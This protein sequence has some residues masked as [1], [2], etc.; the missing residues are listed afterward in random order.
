MKR[1]LFV[2]DSLNGGG[3]EKILL[4]VIGGLDKELYEI[5]LQVIWNRGYYL[6]RIPSCV[7]YHSIISDFSNSFLGKA[8]RRAFEILLKR[9]NGQLLHKLFIRKKYDVEI[10]FLEGASTK[11]VSGASCRKI[12]WVHIDMQA[13]TWY[14]QFYSSHNQT[15][16]TYRN[17]DKIC[18]VSNALK[19]VFIEKFGISDKCVVVYNPV[20]EKEIK[21]LS[22]LPATTSIRAKEKVFVTVGRLEKQKGYDRLIAAA[23]RLNKQ[24]YRFKIAILGSGSL[25][26]E[27]MQ[28]C[29]ELGVQEQVEFLGYQPNPYSIISQADVFICSSRSEGFSTAVTEALV[30]GIPVI[31]TDC[32]GMDELLCGGS[33][34]MIFQNSVDGIENGMKLILDNETIEQNLRMAA[35]KRG[36]DFTMNTSMKHIEEII[37]G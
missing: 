3:A 27:L 32:A 24:Q 37:N 31:T 8:K 16:R 33:C 19:E 1:I 13:N 6:E 11:I 20:D 23:A 18:H 17:F 14:E 36:N 28:Q 15:T 7:N 12:A 21:K 9:G 5:D 2:I 4:D 35:Q 34:G 30:L 10:A 22:Q 29:Y 26:E 25:E